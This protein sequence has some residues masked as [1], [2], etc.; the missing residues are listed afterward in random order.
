MKIILDNNYSNR[1]FIMSY[2]NIPEKTDKI[3]VKQAPLPDRVFPEI[4]KIL[5]KQVIHEIE[6]IAKDEN[7]IKSIIVNKKEIQQLY[8]KIREIESKEVLIPENE[9][10][11]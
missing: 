2:L 8:E 5:C 10:E 11:W 7:D 6:I 4:Q 3:K 1:H 9:I